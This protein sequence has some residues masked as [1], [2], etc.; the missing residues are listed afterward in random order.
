MVHERVIA[1]ELLTREGLGDCERSVGDAC[2]GRTGRA[3]SGPSVQRVEPLDPEHIPSQRSIHIVV[4][5]SG[6]VCGKHYHTRGTEAITVRRPALGRI[7]GNQG[8]QDHLIPE[9][10]VTRSTIPPG[11]AHAVQNLG[12]Q[13]MLLVSCRDLAHEP[14]GADVVREVLIE[15]SGERQVR[16]RVLADSRVSQPSHARSQRRNRGRHL[17]AAT[18]QCDRLVNVLRGGC[19]YENRRLYISPGLDTLLFDK[20]IAGVDLPHAAGLLCDLNSAGSFTGA[21]HDACQAH[22]PP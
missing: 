4:T 1:H 17:G 6:C 10:V 8:V 16:Q 18:G 12:T 22:H 21:I 14:R 9:G 13:P 19:A 7:R 15:A 11:V 5:A 2:Q 20:Q 3:S